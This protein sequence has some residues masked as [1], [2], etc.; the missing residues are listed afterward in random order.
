MRYRIILHESEEGFA[1]SVPGLPGC[2][3]QGATE[4]EAIENVKDAIREYLAAI[5]DQLR[6]E[7]IREVEVVL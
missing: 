3:S 6:G 1:V 2:W 7:T 5:E 4:D